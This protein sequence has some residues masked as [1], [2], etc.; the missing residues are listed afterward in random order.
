MPCVGTVLRHRR[1]AQLIETDTCLRDAGLDNHI[2]DCT[3]LQAR[4]Q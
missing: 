3:A 4:L 2:Q 1:L